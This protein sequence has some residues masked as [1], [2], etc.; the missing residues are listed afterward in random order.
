MVDMPSRPFE[1]LK[2]QSR[3]R[4]K[5]QKRLADPDYVNNLRSGKR[6]GAIV[7]VVSHLRGGS[8]KRALTYIE[9]GDKEQPLPGENENGE[10]TLPGELVNAYDEW[11]S[12]FE[13]VDDSKKNKVRH[14]THML[15][16]IPQ[17][18]TNKNAR[19]LESVARDLL[20]EQ[21]GDKGYK[22]AFVVHRDTENPHV[23]VIVNNYHR[24][25]DGAKLRLNQPELFVMRTRF[26]ELL[27]ERGLEQKATLKR[28]RAEMQR[29]LAGDQQMVK[30][31]KNWLESKVKT[32]SIDDQEWTLRKQQ[33][34]TI[35]DIR[36]QIKA[37]GHE[38][39]QTMKALEDLRHLSKLLATKDQYRTFNAAVKANKSLMSEKGQYG[40]LVKSLS[41][42]GLKPDEK[43][44]SLKRLQFQARRMA[45]DIAEAELAIKAN[46]KIDSADRD[47]LLKD[48]S[49]R[50]DQLA[51]YLPSGSAEKTRFIVKQRTSPDNEQTATLARLITKLDRS[52][53]KLK[54]QDKA[55][56]LTEKHLRRVL[57]E[58]FTA[59]D[60][61]EKSDTLPDWRKQ[62]LSQS[63]DL[64]GRQLSSVSDLDKMRKEWDA[65]RDLD[66]RF[67]RH[68]TLVSDFLAK[69]NTM[70]S[71]EKR[72]SL[73]LI[74]KSSHNIQRTVQADSYDKKQ[75]YTINVSMQR[76]NKDLY[77]YRGKD[78][79]EANKELTAIDKG[80]ENLNQKPDGK[81]AQYQGERLG[82]RIAA[83]ENKLPDLITTEFDKRNIGERFSRLPD[84]KHIDITLARKQY[85]SIDNAKN[86]NTRL[87]R[88]IDG[89]ADKTERRQL[90]AA[91][92]IIDAARDAI[93][94][95][96]PPTDKKE[97]T[98]ER[99]SIEHRV[100][101][102]ISDSVKEKLNHYYA[103]EK[104]T[105]GIIRFAGNANKKYPDRGNQ[106][107]NAEMGIGKQL[108]KL[109]NTLERSKLPGRL[110]DRINNQLEKGLSKFPT[111][112][113]RAKGQGISRER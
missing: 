106:R 5:S 42:G 81:Q 104:E 55:G 2:D 28:D 53:P 29:I 38:T 94:K 102:S 109:L 18:N 92:N 112:Q 63:L 108:D 33:L 54:D 27:N 30:D 14:A 98:K 107:K 48:L 62:E 78:A 56:D 65:G 84:S 75:A 21:F 52:T 50:M 100:K 8:V 93:S 23:H 46:P 7:K 47:K 103:L 60:H 36:S 99:I 25:P 61:L 111:L 97:L 73:E 80:I 79:N 19:I 37:G 10:Q 9:R 90:T 32:A 89:L 58:Y 20:R 66:M 67:K 64:S 77:Q 86:E 17:E 41:K 24:E 3:L 31:A 45:F 11:K 69:E 85:Q 88:L 13:A 34:D 82:L 70:D 87:N 95:E 101:D 44:R 113:Q 40:Q 1:E 91:V 15:L 22:Y 12:Q 39:E 59:R 110:K 68:K 16:S 26:A 83:L 57:G 74:Q 35:V 72:Q 96:V 71:Q 49:G 43:Q 4:G 51:G 6:E 105:Q 76:M